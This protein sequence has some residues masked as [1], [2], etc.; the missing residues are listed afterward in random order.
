MPEVL[1][2]EEIEIIEE[3]VVKVIPRYHVILMDKNY[4][5]KV[6]QWII[7]LHAHYNC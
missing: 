1:T 6:I 3:K 5:N 4:L 7:L 2:Q